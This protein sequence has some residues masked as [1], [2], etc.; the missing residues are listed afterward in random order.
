MGKLKLAGAIYDAA[1]YGYPMKK[2]GPLVAA[3]HAAV[4][5]LMDDG[6]Y[7]QICAK[8]GNDAGEI[9]ESKINGAT[10]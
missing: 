9:T 3:V 1:P 6:T 5:S 8:W 4:Q 10:S 2:S 7:K